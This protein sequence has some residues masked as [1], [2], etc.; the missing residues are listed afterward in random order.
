[1]GAVFD[2][3]HRCDLAWGGVH[4]VFIDISPTTLVRLHRKYTKPRPPKGP[5]LCTN[6]IHLT[7]Y[8][9]E[10]CIERG[11]VLEYQKMHAGILQT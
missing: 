2:V 3:C 9:C 6:T 4:R 5:I 11:A 7:L 8:L 10:S 1:M